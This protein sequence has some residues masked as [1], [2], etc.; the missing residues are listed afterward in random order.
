M[1]IA[2]E[3]ARHL[4]QL[5]TIE[6]LVDS[7]LPVGISARPDNMA[8]LTALLDVEDDS[9]RLI[10]EAECLFSA[11]DVALAFFLAQTTR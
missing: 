10:F 1:V 7:A 3:A 2:G 8:V 5:V 6:G 11:R 4:H 9:A